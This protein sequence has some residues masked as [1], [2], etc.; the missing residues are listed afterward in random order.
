MT[1]ALL[2]LPGHMCDRRLWSLVEPDFHKAG[3][4]VFHGDMSG[5]I[6]VETMASAILSEAP[7]S[8]VAVGLSMGGIIALE[9]VRQE[10]SRMAALI[11]SD[12]NA[13]PELPSR[14]AA[15]RAQQIKV[16]NG[17][18]AEVIRDELKPTYLAPANRERRDILDLTFDMAMQLGSE[19]FLRQSE[20]LITRPDSRPTL[21]RLDCPSLVLCGAEDPVCPPASHRAMADAIPRAEL[22]IIEGAGHLPP[23][24]QPKRF[25]ARVLNWLNAFQ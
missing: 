9:I 25:S 18:L 22:D 1:A 15:R 20:A 7:Q 6:S 11:I 24:E 14:A 2:M 13:A 16:R 5:H 21:P 23:L 19:V 3:F 8:F 17:R 12:S 10:P 4:E